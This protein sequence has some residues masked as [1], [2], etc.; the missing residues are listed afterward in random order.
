[1]K[2]RYQDIQKL[3]AKLDGLASEIATLDI[4]SNKRIDKLKELILSTTEA[5]EVELAQLETICVRILEE[6]ETKT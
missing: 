6:V 4:Q 3:S 1:M 5:I 2:N